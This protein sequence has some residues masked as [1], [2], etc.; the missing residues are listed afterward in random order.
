MAYE[1]FARP[2]RSSIEDIITKRCTLDHQ[3]SMRQSFSITS[4]DLASC[5]DRIIH[6]AA[7]LTLHRIGIY[8]NRITT[9]FFLYRK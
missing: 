4:C 6:T 1:Q 5:Y 7:A 3:H 8:H 9:I 2:N